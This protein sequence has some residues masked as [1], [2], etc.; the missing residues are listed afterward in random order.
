ML[1][2]ALIVA[3]LLLEPS[4][5]RFRSKG[6]PAER[7]LMV[8]VLLTGGLFCGAAFTG[9]FAQDLYPFFLYG[10]FGVPAVTWIASRFV[11][12]RPGAPGDPYLKI[13]MHC[14]HCDAPVSFARRRQGD[15]A[16][17]PSCSGLVDVPGE[18]E[19]ARR[20]TVPRGWSEGAWV[21]LYKN[22]NPTVVELHRMRLEAEGIETFEADS[23]TAA[24]DPV[25]AFAGGGVRLMVLEQ[26]LDRARLLLE[27]DEDTLDLPDDFVSE[28]AEEVEPSGDGEVQFLLESLV[29]LVLV[30]ILLAPIWGSLLP[31]LGLGRLPSGMTPDD[32]RW[33]LLFA[34]C[35][36]VAT[37]RAARFYHRRGKL[38]DRLRD[39]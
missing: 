13:D 24:A 28:P 19:P 7:I 6:R 32:Y 39:A 35:I 8:V 34:L 23:E 33:N 38:P 22:L 17:C 5:Y 30:P 4:Y 36:M 37:I 16:L 18:A 20:K 14:P 21:T 31:D 25:L 29:I 12:P 2:L 26:D 1:L 11:V 10:A 27:S 9:L 15:A 3:V